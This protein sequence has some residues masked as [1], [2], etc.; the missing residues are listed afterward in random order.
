MIELNATTIITARTTI[1]LKEGDTLETAETNGKTV[2]CKSGQGYALMLGGVPYTRMTGLYLDGV[3]VTLSRGVVIGQDVTI[4]KVVFDSGLAGQTLELNSTA[5][6]LVF[7]N[8]GVV[9]ASSPDAPITI[10]GQGKRS[11]IQATGNELVSIVGLRLVNAR[12]Y[13]A[14]VASGASLELA[15]CLVTGA[16]ASGNYGVFANSG[17]LYLTNNTIAGNKASGSLVT[18]GG[19]TTILNTIIALNTASITNL[20][21]DATIIVGKTDPGF[22]DAANGDYTLLKTSSAIDIGLNSATRLRS[23]VVIEYDLAG[24]ERVG[25]ASIVDAG[26]FEYTV[27]LEDRETPS[28]V[29]P[30]LDDVVDLTD[31]EI[32]LREALAYAGTTYRHDR[33]AILFDEN[34]AGTS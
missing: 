4:N 8:G 32:S 18:G 10:D 13:V 16:N 6:P 11:L 31:N 21:Y 34:G 17:N 33:R 3:A 26:A 12:G 27:A 28:T 2:S 23:G 15:N 5:G 14:H 30:P 25:A 19:K 20:T 22:T 7:E 1:V 29:V 9:Y 24:N